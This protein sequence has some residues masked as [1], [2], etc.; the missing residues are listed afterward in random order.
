MKRN[1][2]RIQNR[3]LPSTKRDLHARFGHTG[4]ANSFG[5]TNHGKSI[6]HTHKQGE[7]HKKE[8]YRPARQQK[9]GFPYHNKAS[10]RDWPRI[11]QRQSIM[12]DNSRQSHIRPAYNHTQHT[13]GSLSAFRFSCRSSSLNC[14]AAIRA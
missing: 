2:T 4:E 8:L 9:L 1:D 11:I 13:T 5:E 7:R 14:S 12:D 3:D 10:K 6:L